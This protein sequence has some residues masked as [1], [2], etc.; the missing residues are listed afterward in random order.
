MSHGQ[1][2]RGGLGWGLSI[3]HHKNQLIT[4]CLQK[5][6]NLDGVSD[7]NRT[8]EKGHEI[9]N[10]ELSTDIWNGGGGGEMCTTF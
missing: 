10:L 7:T 4:D 9:W 6:S 3:I 8:K 2:I 5:A 1:Q